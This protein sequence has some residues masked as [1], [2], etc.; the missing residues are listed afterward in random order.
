MPLIATGDHRRSQQ[1]EKCVL[2]EAGAG[3]REP[4]GAQPGQADESVTEEVAALAHVVVDELPVG[5]GN[6][7]EESLED[8]PQRAAGA[9]GA[10]SLCRLDEDDADADGHGQPDVDPVP[11]A[12]AITQHG[13]WA[14]RG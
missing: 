5:R 8:A 2:D 4:P 12:A 10:E 6:G 13:S 9:V 11:E 14:P 1:G 7:P 3:Q